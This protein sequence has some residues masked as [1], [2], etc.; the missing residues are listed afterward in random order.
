MP[1]TAIVLVLCT[2][3][4]FSRSV[5]CGFMNFD[6]QR[7]VYDNPHVLG[8]FTVE[9]VRWA[10]TTTHMGSWHPLT[11]FSLML[12]TQLWGTEPGSY[13]ATGVLI[14]GINAALVFILLHRLTG[15]HARSAATAALWAMH[16]LRV[17]SVTWI[18]ERKDV[19]CVMFGLASLIAYE[20]YA[21]TAQSRSRI[22]WYGATWGLM[23]MS[24]ASKPMT[25][26]L[27]CVMILLDVWPLERL[28]FNEK[29]CW[30]NA[31]VLVLE[32]LPGWMMAVVFSV[33]TV[34]SQ[35]DTGAV[36]STRMLSAA[37]RVGTALNGYVTYLTKTFWPRDLALFYPLD[38]DQ[39]HA[40]AW[41][42]MILLLATVVIG[43]ALWRGRNAWAAAVGWLWFLG[44]LVPVVGFVQTGFQSAADRYTY[45]PC[46]GLTM[47]V[48]WVAADMTRRVACWLSVSKLLATA[49]HSVAALALLAT[50]AGVTWRQIG[51]WHSPLT[52]WPHNIL[53]TPVNAA[54]HSMFGS[55]LIREG[56][57]RDA[58]RIITIA[59]EQDP[60]DYKSFVN[61]S[62]L[63]L[64]TRRPQLAERY[65]AAALALD[66]SDPAMNLRMANLL[67]PHGPASYETAIAHLRKAVTGSPDDANAR[68]TLAALL[69]SVGRPVEAEVHWRETLRINPNHP[70]ANIHFGDLLLNQG[71][72][73]Q[74]ISHFQ[75]AL[76]SSPDHPVARKK[77]AL[78]FIGVRQYAQAIE[79]I[80]AALRSD[81]RDPVMWL[82]LGMAHLESNRPDIALDALRRATE[83]APNNAMAFRYRAR[84][85]SMM[86]LTDEAMQ[87]EQAAV[88]LE[89]ESRRPPG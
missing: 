32:K 10:M 51:F 54:A 50:T 2:L 69:D 89:A 68:P 53:I 23:A 76:A 77:L 84:A 1:L 47:G 12:D 62:S 49:W 17:E 31:A 56:R 59:I 71:K 37:S 40:F 6:D 80:S 67:I 5:T 39:T 64:V 21:R 75:A 3:A 85:A 43:L 8:G 13:H 16:P 55:A 79:H 18:A 73:Q 70:D 34:R 27:P 29:K 63:A 38:P 48:V 24:L 30:R 72:P 42:V 58:E 41:P 45:F 7:Y 9:S 11:W 20:R 28:R 52:M 57:W 36:V 15:S 46:I 86:K 66:D 26:T 87:S 81:D 33:M 60:G 14:H 61:L 78:A 25:V 35:H 74:A 65:T 88:K 19:L 44:T 82:C 22:G 83:L 4:L